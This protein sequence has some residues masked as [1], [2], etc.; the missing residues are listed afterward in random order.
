MKSS[1]GRWKE[2]AGSWRKSM[3][4]K[5]PW[6]IPPDGL[7][8][9]DGDFGL[10]PIQNLLEFRNAVAH[11]RVH[12]GFGTLDVI[13]KIITEKLNVRDG[14][15]RHIRIAEV[16]GEQYESYIADVFRRPEPW[17]TTKL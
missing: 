12:V 11:T 8:L 4:Y 2:K 10:C 3:I 14:G 5:Q 1:F 9:R 15:R 16:S 13:V 6:D 7:P 17:H